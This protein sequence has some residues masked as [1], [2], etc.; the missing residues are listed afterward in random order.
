MLNNI[1]L[2]VLLLT[3]VGCSGMS[4]AP[5]DAT[6]WQ[7]KYHSNPTGAEIY[8]DGKYVGVT[9]IAYS[10]PSFGMEAKKVVAKFPSGQ[11]QA[12]TSGYY[13]FEI[14]FDFVENRATINEYPTALSLFANI[15]EVSFE[16]NKPKSL[17]DSIIQNDEKSLL[18]YL[19][20]GAD[21]NQIYQNGLTPLF[22]AVETNN[23]EFVKILLNKGAS[24]NTHL[25]DGRF[26]LIVASANGSTEIVRSLLSAG[27]DPNMINNVGGTSLIW[28][29]TKGHI[30]I[31]KLLLERNA[32]ITIKENSGST[33]LDLALK[34]NNYTIAELIRAKIS[35]QTKP[36][37]IKPI[38]KSPITGYAIYTGTGWLTQGGYI[39][40]NYH[41]IEGQIE[42]QVRFN[43]I[44]NDTYNVNIVLSDRYND[45]AV[46]DIE[47]KDKM[48][49][50]G[51]PI[52]R[53]L[54]RVGEDVFT[55]GY[56][57]T[58][59]MG[60]NPKVTNGIISS[61]SGI[62]DDPRVIQTTVAIQ[63]GNSG[64]PLLNMK[65]E[66]V[67]VTTSSLRAQV[68]KSGID[69]PQS[70]N[71]AVKSAY[72]LALLSSLTEKASYP[73]VTFKSS[74]L[75]EMIPE[76]QNSI[77]QVIVKSNK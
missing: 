69:I 3:L 27:A 77:V 20:K 33:A 24:P 6:K 73:S 37:N 40:T 60:K 76:I 30:E 38:S 7:A 4:Y 1:S 72:V 29:S 35:T 5:D 59:I 44:S 41:V 18:S 28:A 57:K 65:G 61:L 55:I 2:V 52:S 26:P 47:E 45:L 49:I 46:L 67:G 21:V 10:Y 71:Y 23:L 53:N 70:V 56:P 74:N 68:S 50:R 48:K 34:S 8:V 31:V 36:S 15:R 42:T 32:D 19:E 16:K 14:F 51:I 13:T 43:S 11:E 54:P 58:S 12:L 75:E 66:V 63:S 9:P 64:G 22:V 17:I 62:Q 39:V 25:S